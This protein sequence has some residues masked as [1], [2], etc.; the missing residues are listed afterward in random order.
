MSLE[1]LFDYY[2]SDK[3]NFREGH[4]YSIFYEEIASKNLKTILEI[5][6]GTD[7]TYNGSCGSIRAWLD[8]LPNTKIYGFDIKEP[9]QDLKDNEKFHFI[10]GDQSKMEDLIKLKNEIPQCDVIIDDGSHINEHQLLT[11]NLLWTKIVS[12]G[13][14]IIEDVHCEWGGAPLTKETLS[15]HPNFYKYIGKVNEG[16]VF[17]K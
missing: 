11:F 6:I 7:F 12:G 17:K 2:G 13:Y 10:L 8:W 1:E 15:Q 16:M 14:Y 4:K 9:P 5:G 3:A